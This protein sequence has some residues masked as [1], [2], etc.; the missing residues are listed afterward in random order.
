MTDRAKIGAGALAV[1]AAIALFVVLQGGED[2][3]SPA[4][5]DQAGS[6]PKDRGGDGSGGSEPKPTRE[7]VPVI[8]LQGGE[9]VDGVQE[10]EVTSGERARFRIASDADGEIHVHGYD[11]TKP[12]AAGGSVSFDFP[13]TLEG[14]YEIELHGADG[15]HVVVGQL[16]VQP[17]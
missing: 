9:P 12:V 4:G 6:T 3:S 11:D 8:R 1:I 14:G 16:K 13:A 5:D 10:V 17:G 2:S 15:A 7:S